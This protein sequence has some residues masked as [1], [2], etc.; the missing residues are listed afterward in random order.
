MVTRYLTIMLL[1]TISRQS[2]LNLSKIM[3]PVHFKMLPQRQETDGRS[4][5]CKLVI[6]LLIARAVTY[7]QCRSF[8]LIRAPLFFRDREL[9]VHE[10]GI[11]RGA[12]CQATFPDYV[13]HYTKNTKR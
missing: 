9:A 10:R 13:I 4:S 8:S 1:L 12:V 3:I 11:E 6:R 2:F 7:R 5:C